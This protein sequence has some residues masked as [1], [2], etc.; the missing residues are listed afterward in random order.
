MAKPPVK[1]ALVYGTRPE[2][3]KLS[4]FLR[5]FEKKKIPYF[6][7]HSGQHYSANMDRVFFKEL[8][9]PTPAYQ[10]KIKSRNNRQG[11]HVA[12]MITRIED[13]FY[14][15][16]PTHVF[17]QGDTNTVM[18][19]ALAA[20]KASTAHR[21]SGLRF[22]LCHV[23]AGLRSFDR[24]M[25]EEVNR[26]VTDHL[27]DYLFV[28]T[29]RSRRN[30]LKEGIDP[31]RIF[32]TGNS[33]VDAVQQ[34]LRIAHRRLDL[35]DLTA[36]KK[37]RYILVTLHRQENVDD[38]ARLRELLRGIE[39]VSLKFNLR[40]VF[41][42]HPRT[43]AKIDAFGIRLSD[44]FELLEPVGYLAFLVLQS[45]AGIVLSDS[46]GI[47]EESCILKVPCVTLR[48]TTERPETIEVGANRLA[49]VKSRDIL[50]SA[51]IM[52]KRPRAWS[53]PYGDGRSA[54]RMLALIQKNV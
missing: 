18:A 4:P 28:P 39:L 44:R 19:G 30:A 25:P 47:Q 42:I 21:T 3:I 53:N 40:V 9:L 7:I 17:V 31:K 51:E 10:L 14:K 24:D 2:I 34:N 6:Q 23:E 41:P 49:G 45:H 35:S 26:I 43:R 32:V 29:E 11:D 15:E 13:V 37:G 46:G 54:E 50:K 27:S 5:L 22:R 33:V 48:T 38:A 36:E 20:A 1:I 8:E 52:M 16:K 12:R